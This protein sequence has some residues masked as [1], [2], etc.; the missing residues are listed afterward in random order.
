MAKSKGKGKEKELSTPERPSGHSTATRK[1]SAA[2]RRKNAPEHLDLA[3]TAYTPSTSGDDDDDEPG[4]TVKLRPD[5]S[6]LRIDAVSL[7]DALPCWP[8]TC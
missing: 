1:T 4:I 8:L 5:K 7:K 6:G 2:K 3:T